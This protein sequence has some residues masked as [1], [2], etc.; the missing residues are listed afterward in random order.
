MR[1]FKF[2]SK[3]LIVLLHTRC[4]SFNMFTV[5]QSQIFMHKRKFLKKQRNE[6][7]NRPKE[8]VNQIRFQNYGH[9]YKSYEVSEHWNLE[10]NEST[11]I[12]TVKP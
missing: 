12:H 8:I 3:S 9:H 10:I 6:W 11:C 4:G 7:S 5:L 1:N 2:Y